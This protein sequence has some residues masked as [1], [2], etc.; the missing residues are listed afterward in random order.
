VVVYTPH[1]GSVIVTAPGYVLRL[2]RVRPAKN[3]PTKNHARAEVI[4]QGVT[5]DV[6][7]ETNGCTCDLVRGIVRI[8]ARTACNILRRDPAHDVRSIIAAIPHPCRTTQ[9]P[10]PKAA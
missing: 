7:H 8:A 2:F 4:L 5:V 10:T 9:T 3:H 6:R 1:D